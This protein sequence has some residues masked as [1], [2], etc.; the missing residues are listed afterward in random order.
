MYYRDEPRTWYCKKCKLVFP[1]PKE[2]G[3]HTIQVH[4]FYLPRSRNK[5]EKQII[6]EEIETKPEPP[7]QIKHKL[8]HSDMMSYNTTRLP[9]RDYI[10]EAKQRIEEKKQLEIQGIRQLRVE[11]YI[12]EEE[13][14]I[15]V[16]RI[17]R[18]AYL[19]VFLKDLKEKKE[20]EARHYALMQKI[21]LQN[22]SRNLDN[23]KNQT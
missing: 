11:G 5:P 22:L 8:F 20:K 10:A 18:P 4:G 19:P 7:R 17:I 13:A 6:V 9:E 2:I 1:S 12:S 15:G 16:L 21:N 14:Q 3:K 23:I